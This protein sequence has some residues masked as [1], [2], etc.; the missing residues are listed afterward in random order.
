MGKDISNT[1]YQ[2]GMAEP[3]LLMIAVPQFA[4]MSLVIALVERRRT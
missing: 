3:L 2:P 1:V 4:V